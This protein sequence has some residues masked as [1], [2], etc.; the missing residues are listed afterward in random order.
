MREH[1]KREQHV[2]KRLSY[3][4]QRRRRSGNHQPIFW[5]FSA[6]KLWCVSEH[7]KNLCIPRGCDTKAI[8]KEEDLVHIE[9]ISTGITCK[10]FHNTRV[11][12][13]LCLFIQSILWPFA[14]N[15]NG[16]FRIC[17]TK[18][19]RWCLVCA[20]HSVHIWK[21]SITFD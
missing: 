4:I 8:R 20:F 18:P 17:R 6:F 9:M 12:Y 13:S 2:S 11:V 21:V 10:A 19:P 15:I 5:L 14:E 7:K 3:F 1:K 16:I